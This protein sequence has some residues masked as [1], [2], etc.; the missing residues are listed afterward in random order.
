MIINYEAC[1]NT[2]IFNPNLEHDI[3]QSEMNSLIKKAHEAKDKTCLDYIRTVEL[4]ECQDMNYRMTIVSLFV[5]F[6]RPSFSVEYNRLVNE[7]YDLIKSYKKAFYNIL[8]FDAEVKKFIGNIDLKNARAVMED[9][10]EKIQSSIEIMLLNEQIRNLKKDYILVVKELKT[11]YFENLPL[12]CR[13]IIIR[14]GD[15]NLRNLLAFEY[16]MPIV[17]SSQVI[18]ENTYVAI[19]HLNNELIIEPSIEKISLVKK[20]QDDVLYKIIDQPSYSNSP[21]KMFAPLSNTRHIDII[22]SNDW[23]YGY[24]PIKSEF[25]FMTKNYIPSQKEQVEYYL[26]FFSKMKGKEIIVSV[27]NFGPLKQNSLTKDAFTDLITL[28]KYERLYTINMESIAEASLIAGTPVKV[29]V[30]MIRIKEEVIFW[31]E[32]IQ[33]AFEIAGAEKPEVGIYFETESAYEFYEDYKDLDFAIIGLNDLIEEIT[34]DYTRYDELTKEEFLD[35]FWPHLRDLHQYLRTYMLQVRHMVSGNL[36]KNPNIFR[37]LLASGFREFCIPAQFIR[38]CES[39]ID[40]YTRTRGT[41]IG[42]AAQRLERKMMI[43]QQEEQMSDLER[44]MRK[45]EKL[46]R[47]RQRQKENRQRFLNKQKLKKSTIIDNINQ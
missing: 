1:G 44:L 42:V 13:G 14:K 12:N 8:D 7:S 26:K 36:L 28:E 39:S 24:G 5:L 16:L 20:I 40:R 27:P 46:K 25:L 19:S 41:F 29:I 45:V 34:D 2:F 31:T 17:K 43:K 22:T 21:I 15:E 35:V 4:I 18:L 47:K 11:Y 37:K 30:P 6:S 38:C 10:F 33:D 32:L 3:T 9:I 23:F